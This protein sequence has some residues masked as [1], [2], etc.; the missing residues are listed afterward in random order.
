MVLF[1][2]SY[3]MKHTSKKYSLL[4]CR[5]GVIGLLAVF[6]GAVNAIQ[7]WWKTVEIPSSIQHHTSRL[8]SLF[9]WNG[10]TSAWLIATED[11]LNISNGLILGD[12]S[13]DSSKTTIAWGLTN[14]IWSN[15][16]NSW[17]AWWQNNELSGTNS[18]IGWW[19]GNKIGEGDGFANKAVIAW[20]EGNQIL[21]PT[22]N[23]ITDPSVVVWW[24]DNKS[25]NWW[26]VLWG[27]GNTAKWINN[28][29]LWQ[30]AEGGNWSFAW[31]WKAEQFSAYIWAENWILIG[32]NE[33]KDGINLVINWAMKIWWDNTAAAV[34]WEMRVVN[35]CFYAYDWE[36]RH[37]ITQSAAEDNCDDFENISKPCLF[38]NVCLDTWDKAMAYPQ[39]VASN[40]GTPQEVVCE[41]DWKVRKAGSSLDWYAYCYEDDSANRE[42]GTITIWDITI[43][44]RNLWATSNNI[45]SSDSYGYKYQ[46][47]NNHWFL[48]SDTPTVTTAWLAWNSSYDNH[49]YYSANWIN[50]TSHDKDVWSDSSHHNWLRWWASDSSSNNWWLDAISTTA[51]NRQWPCPS[52]W[53]IPSAWERFKL[54]EYWAADYTSNQW[55]YMSN[56]WWSVSLSTRR[57]TSNSAAR[58]AFQAYFKLPFAGYRGDS[59]ASLNYQ[60]SRAGYWSSSPFGTSNPNGAVD[61]YFSS[62]NVY[63]DDGSYRASGF[64]I[65]C[66]K[67][68]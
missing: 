11:R 50:W 20:G 15:S 38:G 23:T 3:S 7:I 48:D 66:F 47:W 57:F 9:V 53:H 41:A 49:G 2:Y 28:L 55:Y 46:R 51:I 25:Q 12:G 34:A 16:S 42:Y 24:Y 17:I 63:A 43:M 40:C 19:I 45:N 67:N 36:Y 44:D 14:K 65:R 58:A 29:V 4:L 35:G 21:P 62:S 8:H 39:R 6:V 33:H 64:P 56:Q 13:S 60:G 54:L 52:G 10:S 1:C 26:T 18:V 30:N 59:D 5:L 32:T 22:S 31:N 37:V 68:K 61:M 27:A